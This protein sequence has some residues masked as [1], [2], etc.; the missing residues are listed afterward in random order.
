MLA[1]YAIKK[2]VFFLPPLPNSERFPPL[3]AHLTT[4]SSSSLHSKYPEFC[5]VVC[6]LNFLF[7]KLIQFFKHTTCSI[8]SGPPHYIL[9][10]RSPCIVL[11]VP[12]TSS[13]ICIPD[14]KQFE[15]QQG[16]NSGS[17]WTN[18]VLL[19]H[20]QHFV[21]ITILKLVRLGLGHKYFGIGL[22]IGLSI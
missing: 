6:F 22:S 10:F 5:S 7:T 2:E 20:T 8:I 15:T 12:S 16:V 19:G 17:L 14:L 11:L 21:I 13:T 3:Q 1:F 9:L 4:L 18:S